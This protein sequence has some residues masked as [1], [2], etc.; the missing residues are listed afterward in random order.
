MREGEQAWW[1]PEAYAKRRPLLLQRQTILAEVRRFFRARDFVEVEVPALQVSPGLE[2]HLQAFATALRAPDETSQLRY[3]HTSPEFACKKLLA[4]GEPRLFTLARVFRNGERAATHHPEFSLLE[5]YRAEEPLEALIE[6]CVALLRHLARACGRRHLLWQGRTVDPFRSCPQ[7]AVQT[8]F[9]RF[10]GIDLLATLQDPLVPDADALRA[11]ARS[12][13]FRV[14]DDDSWEALVT[15]IQ[16]AA[17][18]PELG[19]DRPTFLTDYPLCLAALAR[20]QPAAPHLAERFELYVGGLELANAF[21]EL[22][23]PVEQR[24]RFEADMDLKERLYGERYPIDEDF[25]EALAIMP[26][27]S[28]IALGLDRLVMLLTGAEDIEQVLWAP[29]R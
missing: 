12:R 22:T 21:G 23:D 18:E 14:A 28:G 3:L 5:W 6:D 2:P 26:P 24:R 1:S 8:A 15:K 7:I 17:I 19:R 11:A 4:A 10:A 29:V 20:P 27:A 9:Q 25:L 13:G 16:L